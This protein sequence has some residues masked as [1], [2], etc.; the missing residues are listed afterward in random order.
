MPSGE[1]GRCFTAILATECRG[2]L[3]RSWN[4]EI[5]LVFVQVV[6][7]KTLGL[8]RAREIRAWITRRMDLWARGMNAGLV[9]DSEAEGDA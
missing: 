4:S 1:V 8:R 5:P 3:N 6:L 2:V 9:G 7:T